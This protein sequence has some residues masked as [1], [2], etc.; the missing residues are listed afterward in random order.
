MPVTF[1]TGRRCLSA[2][3]GATLTSA[4][5]VQRRS[6]PDMGNPEFAYEI[7]CYLRRPRNYNISFGEIPFL[8][9]HVCLQRNLH[10]TLYP[11]AHFT[12]ASRAHF[13]APAHKNL[14][15]SRPPTSEEAFLLP[16]SF[17]RRT[18]EAYFLLLPSQATPQILTDLR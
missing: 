18:F 12:R 8:S 10:S 7:S 13:P 17:L 14:L 16:S 5:N 4:V 1:P 9:S 6:G 15:S 2:E 3:Q 11:R